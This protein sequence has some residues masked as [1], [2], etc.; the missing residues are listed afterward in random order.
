MI[1]IQL[2]RKR[3]AKSLNCNFEG[4][5][6]S[7]FI[8]YMTP[9]KEYGFDHIILI[10]EQYA[11]ILFLDCY[12]RVFEWGSMCNVLRVIGDFWSE[13]KKESRTTRIFW[14]LEFDGTIDEYEDV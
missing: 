10:G 13:V 2:D 8:F 9:V 14:G 3:V 12:G 1:A 5:D 11:G 6:P 4:G 7:T